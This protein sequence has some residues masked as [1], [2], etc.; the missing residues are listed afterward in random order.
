[1]HCEQI[2]LKNVEYRNYKKFDVTNSLKD[3]DQEMI[4]GE[5][6]K[7]SNDMYSTFADVFRSV[8]DRHAPLKRKM[9]RRNQGLFMT[10]QL[11]KKAKNTCN[12]LNKFDRN[13]YFKKFTSKGFV[14]NKAF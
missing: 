9:I 13:S 10:K 11:S 6:Y 4:S 1:M 7:Y 14:S 3:L 12:S 8:L 2:A 5:M